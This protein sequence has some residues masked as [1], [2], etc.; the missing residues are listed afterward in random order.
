MDE[1]LRRAAGNET[2]GAFPVPMP[3]FGEFGSVWEGGLGH[4]VSEGVRGF[5]PAKWNESA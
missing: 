4:S 5:T 1:L 2:G 3:P